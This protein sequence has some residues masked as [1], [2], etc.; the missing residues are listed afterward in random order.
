[1]SLL[2]LLAVVGI[3]GVLSA[4]VA[5][6]YGR[7]VLGNIGVRGQ[8][9][10]LSLGLVEAQRLAVRSGRLHG[11][12]FAGSLGDASSW[13]VVAVGDT[14]DRTVVDG[15]FLLSDDYQLTTNAS[16][17]LFDFE[18]NATKAVSISLVGPNQTWTV[19]TLTLSGLIDCKK[20]G[21]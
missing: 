7:D 2:E 14:G 9:R 12:Q 8:A 6:R 18:G 19:D 10:K 20:S 11:V 21:S 17:I 3:M 13:S 4:T 15:P 16:E 1:M 5:A